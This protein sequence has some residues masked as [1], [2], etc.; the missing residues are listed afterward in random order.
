[1][2]R[3]IGLLTLHAPGITTPALPSLLGIFA[4]VVGPLEMMLACTVKGVARMIA[5]HW[6][7]NDGKRTHVTVDA[8][9]GD[10][11]AQVVV[12]MR[13]TMQGPGRESRCP[14]LCMYG[15]IVS[16]LHPRPAPTLRS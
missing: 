5:A 4:I 8:M 14:D 9:H 1:M 16:L 2:R 13:D 6:G 3:A 7:T 15:P 11:P 12:K 10:W